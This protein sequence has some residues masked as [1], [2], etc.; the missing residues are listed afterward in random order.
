LKGVT[1]GGNAFTSTSTSRQTRRS[2]GGVAPDLAWNGVLVPGE[3]LFHPESAATLSFASPVAGIG[4]Q[5]HHDWLN[6]ET[7]Q[8]LS[9]YDDQNLL[10][11]ELSLKST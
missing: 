9:L 5:I 3:N 10:L 1:L 8:T 7:T 11:D 6:L 2:Q 4:C